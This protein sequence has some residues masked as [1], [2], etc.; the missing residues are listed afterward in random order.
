MLPHVVSTPLLMFADPIG[1]GATVGTR[2]Q[3]VPAYSVLLKGGSRSSPFYNRFFDPGIGLTF[4]AL[5]FNGDDQPEVGVA[6]T[7]SLFRDWVQVG[8]GHDFGDD[9]A[10]WFV[11]GA[12]PIGSLIGS[13]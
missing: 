1:S 11:G 8:Y 12:V 3:T 9:R 5:D 6:A 10:F 2:F 13:R 4:A 7:L